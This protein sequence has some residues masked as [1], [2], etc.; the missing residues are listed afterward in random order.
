MMTLF[1][2]KGKSEKMMEWKER[3]FELN[4]VY[5]IRMCGIKV[6]IIYKEKPREEFKCSAS[7]LTKLMEL[8]NS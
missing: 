3:K 5:M 8:L 2:N 1:T 7:D 4:D 6:E